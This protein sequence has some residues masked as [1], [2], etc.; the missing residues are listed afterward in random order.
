MRDTNP[1]PDGRGRDAEADV[2][3]FAALLAEVDEAVAEV[4]VESVAASAQDDA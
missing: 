3:E 1:N 4:I 2:D